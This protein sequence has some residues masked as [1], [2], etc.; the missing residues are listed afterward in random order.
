MSDTLH[1]SHQAPKDPHP[2]TALIMAIALGKTNHGTTKLYGRAIRA[3]DVRACG[4]GAY[5]F[6]LA[7]RFH[8][9]EALSM[10]HF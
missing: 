5:S 3:K 8:M 10:I 1:V 7:V 6:Y 4:M 9:T 2:W